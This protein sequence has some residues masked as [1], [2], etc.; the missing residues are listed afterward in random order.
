MT[1]RR[2][3]AGVGIVLAVLLAGCGGGSG[4]SGTDLAVSGVGPSSQLNGGDQAIFTM[5]VANEGQYTADNLT[6]RNVTSQLSTAT[7]AVTC[8]A[9]NGATCP[10]ATSATMT[11]SSMP[12][13]GSLVFQITATS[14]LGASGNVSD[15]MSVSSESTETNADNNTITVSAPVVSNDVS[16]TATA[17][18]G[19][20]V[21]GPATFTMLVS[22]AGPDDAKSVVL[23]T[24]VSDTVTFVP[25]AVSCIANPNSISGGPLAAVPT[26]QSD[27]TL[28][29]SDIPAGASLTCSVPVTVKDATDGFAIVTMTATAPGDSH[30][31]NNAGTGSVSA[32]LVNDVSVTGT[33]PAGPLVGNTATFTMVVAN[34]GPSTA[35]QAVITNALSSSLT[36]ASPISCVPAG[37][38][39]APVLQ[40]N[41]TLIAA[42]IPANAQLTCSINVNVL[43]GTN[44]AVSD[45]MAVSVADDPK[46]GNNSATAVVQ[47][48]LVNNV[49]V[50]VNP[51][52]PPPASVPGGGTTTFGFVVSNTGPATASNVTL[53]NTLT[54]NLAM[55]G[56]ITCT[57]A[58]GAAAPTGPSAGPL[59]SA[60][61]PVNG[62][63]TCSVP[64]KVA[65]GA[66]GTVGATFAVTAANDQVQLNNSATASTV[67]ASADLGASVS[68]A[69]TAAAGS[70]VT[71]VVTIANPRGGGTVNNVAITWSDV[72]PSGGHVA[73]DAASSTCTATAGATCP[74]TIAPSMSVASMLTGSTLTFN[75][76]FTTTSTDRGDIQVTAGVSAAGDPNTANNTSTATSTVV[77]PR[78]GTYTAF[79]ADGNQYSIAYDFDADTYTVNGGTA[80]HFAPVSGSS[81]EFAVAGSNVAHF[82]VAQDLVV[83]GNAFG[84]SV[85][86]YVAARSFV[87]T[88]TS[89]AGSYDVAL[90]NVSSGSATT[91]GASAQ[92]NGNTLFVCSRSDG[93]VSPPTSSGCPTG[94]LTS[95]TLVAN[96]DQTF[97]AQDN[98][99]SYNFKLMLA[100]SGALKMLLS[101]AKAADNSQQLLLGLPDA[102]A[103]AGGTFGSATS[104]GD[105][106]TTV[107]TGTSY[108][109]TGTTAT[110]TA[111]LARI[112]GTGAPGSMLTGVSTRFGG[113]IF[114][115]QASPLEVVVG[116]F[117]GAASGLLQIGLP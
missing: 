108:S 19:P 18:A 43:P 68:S 63:L 6:I 42:S 25:S 112:S 36:L 40:P 102:A 61:I 78:N 34:A 59:T 60:S 70:P 29:S 110:D 41:G 12:A 109:F 104:D 87:T 2:L 3:S 88:A 71:F 79:A 30:S 10:S 26:L 5:T 15:T 65:A 48:T 93:V 90:R 106:G 32:T 73:F 91:H 100:S 21:E 33:A 56:A 24:T 81:T 39:T 111:T 103:L 117:A 66:N 23:A 53:T 95:Y 27:G 16:V 105:Y 97:T 54:A 86:P 31:G 8:T 14:N 116:G 28:L 92:V 99:S 50:E 113:P 101:S 17:P 9:K 55:N 84:S 52:T 72:L 47:A 1:I 49:D 77:D 46:T 115:I 4:R 75:L 83:G 22:N 20:L 44:G 57:A 82:R 38:A 13:G 64:V 74:A 51:N 58:G 85:L 96:S 94:S 89:L 62:T 114:A 80:V 7:L 69:A 11:V 67:A 45:S 107:L 76:V 98:A 37:G 35:T